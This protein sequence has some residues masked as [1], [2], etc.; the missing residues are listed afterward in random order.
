M[1]H[2]IEGGRS[3]SIRVRSLAITCLRALDN[4]IFG[5]IDAFAGVLGWEIDRSRPFTRRYRSPQF[6]ALQ[7]CGLCRGAGWT[8]RDDHVCGLCGGDGRIARL[9]AGASREK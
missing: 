1:K 9:N 3:L 7:R 4:W 6:D 5:E 2:D 8:G